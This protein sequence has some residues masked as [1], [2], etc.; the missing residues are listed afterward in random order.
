[1][2]G[3]DGECVQ[4]IVVKLILKGRKRKSQQDA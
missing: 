3:R 4:Y 2:W 1:M